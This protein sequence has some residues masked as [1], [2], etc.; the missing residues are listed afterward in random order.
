MSAL[1]LFLASRGN[2]VFGFDKKESEI[3]NNLVSKGIAVNDYNL[4][5]LCNIVVVSSA[6]SNEDELLK[7]LLR[8]NKKIINRGELLYKISSEFP[9][10]IGVAGTHGKT[11][12]TAMLAHIL[13][14]A[15][16]SFSAH[17]GGLDSEFGNMYL[18]GENIFLSEVCEYKK[19]IA[20]FNSEMALLLN[21]ANDHV[22][23]YGNFNNLKR[24]FSSYL[25][26]SK[27]AI[28]DYDFCDLAPQNAIT[29][30]I[31][32]SN[33]DYYAKAIT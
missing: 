28:V 19:N 16:L 6:I 25:N 17:I 23:S 3:T 20:L 27:T 21:V 14:C 24:E 15:N 30:S 7:R 13:N 5:D 32:N 22:E 12:T 2:K 4:I 8:K 31:N 1:A 18:K 33:A 26:R 9:L 11:T 10:K 29:F